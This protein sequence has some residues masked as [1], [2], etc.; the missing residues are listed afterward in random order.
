MVIQ[1]RRQ[2]NGE[3]SMYSIPTRKPRSTNTRDATDAQACLFSCVAKVAVMTAM[4]NL[5][6]KAIALAD[7]L[8]SL[9][10]CRDRSRIDRLG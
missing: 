9:L 3:I 8:Q 5:S 7:M 2:L 10:R 6:W 1:S 4:I